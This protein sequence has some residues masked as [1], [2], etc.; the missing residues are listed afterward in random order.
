MILSHISVQTELQGSGAWLEQLHNR[1]K[2]DQTYRVSLSD[3]GGLGI[4]CS[5]RECR[6]AFLSRCEILYPYKV[7]DSHISKHAFSSVHH[8]HTLQNI[9]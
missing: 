2:H 4:S 1:A 3:S 8:I 6:K 7:G 9:Q 5:Y